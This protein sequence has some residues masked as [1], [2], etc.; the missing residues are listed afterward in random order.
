MSMIVEPPFNLESM[1][2]GRTIEWARLEFKKTWDDWIKPSVIKTVAAFA[3]DLDNLNGGYVILGVEEDGATGRPILPPHG[4]DDLN[5][6]TVQKQIQGA[7]QAIDPG[8]LP[9]IWPVRF[10]DRT[11]IVLAA[12][13][14][15]VRPYTAPDPK[16]GVRKYW[17]R[18]GS[19]TK[20]AVGDFLRQLVETTGR[21]PF[22]DRRSFEGSLE[23]I[24]EPLIREHLRQVGSRVPDGSV[25][26]PELLR[27][28][29]L[30]TRVN[31]H[32]V[33]RNVAL[34]FFST[35]PERF[36][37]GS[38]IEIASYGPDAAGRVIDE[39]V[40]HGPL[41]D[42]IRSALA[43]LRLRFT[44]SI[45]K[46]SND[47]ASGRIE[48]YPF[49]A[50]EEAI[51]NTVMHRSHELLEPT[52][53]HIFTD[54]MEI[55]SYPGPVASVKVDDLREGASGKSPPLRNRR[56]GELLKEL[57]LA[58]MRG[59]GVPLIHQR[60]RENGSPPPVFDFD[61][62]R[63]YFRVTLP[64]HPRFLAWQTLRDAGV[65]RETGERDR[66]ERLLRATLRK[67]PTEGSLWGALISLTAGVGSNPAADAVIAE[68]L[69]VPNVVDERRIH[70][71][72]AACRG[73]SPGRSS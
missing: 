11:L 33:P 51:A 15:E 69:A 57:R 26:T 48:P 53:I 58:E 45:I 30:S 50:I 59:S 70:E 28:M 17:F 23:D 18:A 9:T 62:D 72:I 22:D 42:Q 66:A 61:E 3:N 14:G 12:Y 16:T 19:E 41:P 44:G 46:R 4:L 60:M 40:I 65:L 52:K 55:I 21:V 24:S 6:D 5:L 34:L 35:E 39:R 63:S 2:H 67:I 1:L 31:G 8:Y 13:A 10:M 36:F 27:R 32:E 73:S 47:P 25:A 68:A 7:C 43:A 38:K 20:E 49:D 64:A 71:A 56:I 37:P 54:R 29:R